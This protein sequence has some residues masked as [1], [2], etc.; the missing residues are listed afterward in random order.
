MAMW[1]K[2]APWKA[3]Y[4]TM[5]L[6][7][8]G[9]LTLHSTHYLLC[10]LRDTCLSW[11]RST[12]QKVSLTCLVPTENYSNILSTRCWGCS[13]SSSSTRFE[14]RA[15]KPGRDLISIDLMNCN[16]WKLSE[17]SSSSSSS[18]S[19]A[20]ASSAAAA[21]AAATSLW[22][23]FRVLLFDI[24]AALTAIVPV[25]LLFFLLLMRWYNNPCQQCATSCYNIFL[26]LSP[27]PMCYESNVYECC[28]MIT[29]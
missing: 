2:N 25:K 13:R 11:I 23:W 27:F 7:F 22:C 16:H 8:Y 14:T 4:A 9:L 10:N 18:S 19:S 15:L 1:N 29:C 20:A 12:S 26:Q 17:S 28:S 3:A 6:L 24:F 21:T 5:F